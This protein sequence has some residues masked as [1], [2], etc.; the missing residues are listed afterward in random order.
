MVQLN[1]VVPI[2]GI[3]ASSHQDSIMSDKT[4]PAIAACRNLV[5]NSLPPFLTGV[6]E[7]LDDTLYALAEKADSSR[8]QN[9]YFDALRAIRKQ[10][11]QVEQQFLQ[12][13][14][15]GYDRFWSPAGQKA[16]QEGSEAQLTEIKLSLVESDDLEES[17]AVNNL[18]SKAEGR[19]QQ[20]IDALNQRFAHL[21][22][23]K[24]LKSED[25]PL[26]PHAICEAFSKSNQM[27]EGP[28]T[29]KLVTY[30][31]FDKQALPLLGNLYDQANVLLADKGILPDLAPEI[32]Y[33]AVISASA[34]RRAAGQE[35][36]SPLD[37]SIA[38]TA[39]AGQISA[40]IAAASAEVFNL[41]QQVLISRRTTGQGGM[42]GFQLPDTGNAPEL[43]VVQ[44]TE[45]LGALSHL[46]AKPKDELTTEQAA[47]L[48]AP[49]T[50]DVDALKSGLAQQLGM[51]RN[52]N[53]QRAIEQADDDTIDM[54][55]MLFDFILEDR[56][57]PDRI[58]AMLSRLQ[59]PILK[60]AL[61]DRNFFGKKTHPA[62]RLLNNLAHACVGWTDD[63]DRS[64][65]SLISTVENIVKRIL[66]EFED[67]LELFVELDK[68][69]EQYL[70]KE[71]RRVE[72]LETR[73]TQATQ[74][75]ERV[76]MSRQE[77]ASEIDSRLRG[78][79]PPDV[80][81]TLLKQGWQEVLALTYLRQGP[82][83]TEWKEQIEIID[84][85]LWSVD[86]RAVGKQRGELLK[87]IPELLKSLREALAAISYDP[88]KMA[89]LFKELQVHHLNC[90]KQTA[91]T[92]VAELLME[93]DTE[94]LESEA[95]RA[96][97]EEEE[98]K[99]PQTPPD[100]YLNKAKSIELGTWMEFEQENGK[101]LRGKLLWRSTIREV[102]VFV[103]HKGVKVLEINLDDFGERLRQRKAK[104][105][106]EGSPLMDRVFNNMLGSLQ[107]PQNSQRPSPPQ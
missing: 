38:G 84:K 97:E 60:V 71:N 85:L 17:L 95:E 48:D 23:K 65:K 6:F 39:Q 37:Q 98:A 92:K 74:G 86:P 88:H 89:Q 77:A 96:L 76:E 33:R 51:I 104:V 64:P 13:I 27:I 40:E 12:T 53:A 5:A 91:D 83:S 67:N 26:G 7:K 14:L 103:N 1:K 8:Q 72:A 94:E 99:K 18:V 63:G 90:L 52:G 15:Q 28:I 66:S 79:R 73:T 10:R 107:Q 105:V 68:E 87:T 80:V 44:R 101:K 24:E 35:E 54:I 19:Y 57:L 106:P 2:N 30:K 25:N 47:D 81:I 78:K 61:L 56:S 9:A 50:I 4:H 46:Q 49:P 45:L 58:K 100:P 11:T 21:L 102:C 75:K 69:F 34:G 55:A 22:Q 29:V 32:R 59:I 42:T 36:N 43:P 16:V 41:L 62:R 93:P 82:E 20:S 70:N 31:L 3:S